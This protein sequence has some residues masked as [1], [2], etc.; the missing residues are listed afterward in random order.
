MFAQSEPI[1]LHLAALGEFPTVVYLAPEPA[2]PISRLIERLACRF[3]EAPP[4]GGAFPTIIPHL[5]IAHTCDAALR[6]RI[7]REISP[8]LPVRCTAREVMLMR[9]EIDGHW[10]THERFPLG[11]GAM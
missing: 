8:A 6:E 10:R 2:A 3:P 5:T 7:M 11:S 9:E 1:E 4:Y